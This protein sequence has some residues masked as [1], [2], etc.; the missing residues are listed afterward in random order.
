MKIKLVEKNF[1]DEAILFIKRFT[2][3]ENPHKALK[4]LHGSLKGADLLTELVADAMLQAYMDGVRATH[5][6]MKIPAKENKKVKKD[7]ESKSE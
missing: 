3:R 6:E 1:M 2:G 5:E 4:Y 7:E